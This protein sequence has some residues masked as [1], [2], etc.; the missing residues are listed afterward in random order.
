MVQIYFIPIRQISCIEILILARRNSFLQGV[1]YH[2]LA[3]SPLIENEHVDRCETQRLVPKLKVSGQIATSEVRQMTR[4]LDLF[5]FLF[6][7]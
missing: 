6:N 1:W 5:F 4:R 7:S 2:P 3:V